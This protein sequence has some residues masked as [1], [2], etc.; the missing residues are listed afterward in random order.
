MNKQFLRYSQSSQLF[1]DL[2]DFDRSKMTNLK[3]K[4]KY[5]ASN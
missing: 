3:E 4:M 1:I 2:I 5:I